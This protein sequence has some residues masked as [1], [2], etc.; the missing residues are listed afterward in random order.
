MALLL[1][2]LLILLRGA[3]RR[4]DGVWLGLHGRERRWIRQPSLLGT[5]C[6]VI[7][8]VPVARI[9]HFVWVLPDW[10]GLQWR[11]WR[12]WCWIWQRFELGTGRSDRHC[13]LLLLLIL[14]FVSWGLL[15]ATATRV[16]TTPA[17]TVRSSHG[18][19]RRSVGAP[20]LCA[21][22]RF[23]E[24]HSAFCS[25]RVQSQCLD[26][27]LLRVAAVLCRVFW[28]RLALAVVA[29]VA[30]PDLAATRISYG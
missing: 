2:W 1:L 8:A 14:D 20:D 22:H 27:A 15:S 10:G 17:S 3:A 7:V 24:T 30:V 11:Q 29:A 6:A 18:D 4:G 13:S 26:L 12:R 5:N 23:F 25:K 9:P 19:S 21:C 16:P 28:G